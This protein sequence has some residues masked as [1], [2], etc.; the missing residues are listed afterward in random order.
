MKKLLIFGVIIVLLGF[1]WWALS[2]LLFDKP[3]DDQLDQEL[4]A[5]LEAQRLVDENR[6]KQPAQNQGDDST[7]EIKTTTNPNTG[8]QQTGP[9]FITDT[10]SHP[11]SGFVEIITSPEEKLIYFRDYDG[12]NGPDLYVYLSKDLEAKDY[13]SLGEQRGN[14]GNIIYGVPLDVDISEYKYVI[15]WCKAFGVLFDYAEIN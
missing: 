3:V 7:T 14:K 6:Q 13:I 4:K 11:A 9:F 15:T 5:R 10:A 2:P 12:T 8:L 1:A